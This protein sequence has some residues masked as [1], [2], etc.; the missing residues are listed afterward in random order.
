MTRVIDF[1]AHAFP[2][3]IA[4]RAVESLEKGCNFEFRARTDGTVA[5]LLASMDSGGVDAAVLCPI[6]TR[7]EQFDGILHWVLGCRSER[8]IP[9]ASVHPASEALEDQL[10]RV[11]QAGLAGV[12]IHP[13]YQMFKLDEPRLDRLYALCSEL[14]LLVA[15]H[16]GYDVAFGDDDSA[17]VER[18][19]RVLDRHGELRFVATHLGGWRQWPRAA[20]LLAGRPNLWFETSASLE[21]MSP[22]EARELIEALG[23][24]RVLFGTDSPWFSHAE[25]RRQLAAADLGEGAE[26]AILGGN[27]ESLLA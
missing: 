17:D 16:C 21:L 24:S 26:A 10:R 4:A 6:A 18:I 19:A 3:A 13:M 11:V 12:K 2:D 9:L 8:L 5:G 1:H 7:P 27:A 20:A 14:G 23:V 15:A 25:E 22:A